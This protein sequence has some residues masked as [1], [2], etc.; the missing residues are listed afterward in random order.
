M[1]SSHSQS[2][3]QRLQWHIKRASCFTRQRLPSASQDVT[4]TEETLKGVTAELSRLL[5]AD[6]LEGQ[7]I[8]QSIGQ[9]ILPLVLMLIKPGHVILQQVVPLPESTSAIKVSQELLQILQPSPELFR[10]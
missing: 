2:V 3:T 1:L 6:T 5:A 4:T 9:S 8:L 10:L 7:K